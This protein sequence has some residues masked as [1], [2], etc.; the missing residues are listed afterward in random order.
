MIPPIWISIRINCFWIPIPI[1]LLWPLLA[2]IWILLG[3]TLTVMLSIANGRLT[4]TG[5][6]WI[7][8][9][10]LLCGLRGMSLNVDQAQMRMKVSII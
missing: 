9:W 6:I 8:S 1:F 4:Q 5:T 2:L 7:E 10:R 3:L